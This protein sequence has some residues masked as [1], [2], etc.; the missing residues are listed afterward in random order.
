MRRQL[1]RKPGEQLA[2]GL[3]Y[4]DEVF[5]GHSAYAPVPEPW[6]DCEH[7]PGDQ[8]IVSRETEL[9]SFVHLEADA[10]SE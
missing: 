9:R 2:A 3:G 5:E 1:V 10:V 8:W 7:V 4:E 6:L